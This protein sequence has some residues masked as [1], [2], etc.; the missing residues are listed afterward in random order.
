M[1]RRYSCA[2]LLASAFALLQMVGCGGGGTSVKPLSV[3]TTSLPNGTVG[4]T[5]SSTLSATGGT[6]P[7]TW[8]QSSGGDMPGG[9]TL[10]SSGIFSGTPTTPGTFGPYV[11]TVKDSANT[12]AASASLSIMV[13][14]NALA[15]TTTSLP[16]G[17]VGSAY[18]FTLTASGGTS[19]YTWTETSGGDLPP[20]VAAV[21]SAGVI[22]GT[23]TTAGTYGPYVFT[24]T[25]S[26]NG[27]K[28]SGSLTITVV[29]E[30]AA[31]C[32]PQ[33]NE[34]GLTSANPY[35]FLLKGSDGHGNPIDVAGSFTP[36]GTGGIAAAVA[37]YN[38]LTT[39]PQA[40]QVNLAASSYSFGP[41]GQGCLYL[42]F[43]GLAPT[44][45]ATQSAATK[46]TFA[47]GRSAPSRKISVAAATG[48]LVS[49]VQFSFA[50]SGFDGTVYHSGR[51]I[52]SD[53]TSGSGTNAAGLIHVQS[54][55]AFVFSALQANYAFGVDGWTVTAPGVLRTAMAGTFA[56]AAG[57]LSNGYADL[58]TANGPSGELTG[59]HGTLNTTIDAT[60]GRGTGSYF[61]TTNTGNLTFDF[62]FYVLNGSDLLLLSTDLSTGTSTNPLLAG[63]ALASSTSYISGALNGYYLLASQGLASTGTTAGNVAEIGTINATSAGTVPTATLYSNV[64]GTYATNQY[65]GSSYT[66]E[67]A[68][69]RV[70][71]TGLTTTPPILYL[72]AGAASDDQI[73]GFL[74]GTDNTASSGVLVNQTTASPTYSAASVTGNYAGST[75]EDVDGSN[76]AFLGVFAFD[77][78]GNYTVASPLT[79]GSLSNVPHSGTI[80]INEDGSGTLDSGNFPLVTNGSVVFAIPNSGDPLLYVFTGPIPTP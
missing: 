4:T 27:T 58:V 9:V 6:A 24:V 63:R 23:P 67:A 7:Y 25:D 8:S 33:G 59:G 66:A 20:G 57:T 76:G 45:A 62:A 26:A 16:N 5:Y 41:S 51:I 38:G 10:S 12:T 72:S 11:F 55:A 69:G 44:S 64:A 18:S 17:V 31:V 53:N 19:P 71:F 56:N 36:N 75:A 68:S 37:D 42:S 80:S 60:T 2:V 3:L 35:A 29:A 30:A 48:T 15:V 50:L 39:G 70:S 78:A 52:E 65:P 47:P 14:G 21:T 1:D 61:V 22:A 49:T 40:L 54:P 77:G 28:M 34:S 74:V 79:T 32:A 13:T 73:V 43:S 46:S